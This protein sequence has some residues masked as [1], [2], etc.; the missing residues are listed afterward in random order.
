MVARP[1]Q[2]PGA[3]VTAF[4]PARDEAGVIEASVR[5]VLG[6][7]EVA[8]LVVV[9]DRSTDGTSE[10]LALLAREEPRLEVLEGRGP[11]EGECGKPAALAAAY[12]QASP[13]SEWLLFVDADVELS[14]GA[15][16]GLL[17]LAADRDLVSAIPQVEL[18]TLVEQAVMPSV[19]ALVLAA[20]GPA[21][22]NGQ[23]IL[24]RR[25]TYDAVGGHQAVIREVLE[26]VRLAQRVH[27][28]NGRLL[29][30]D[31]RKIARTRMYET[32]AELA[33]GWIKNLYP[34]LGDRR[35]AVARWVALTMVLGWIGPAVAIWAGWPY[36]VAAYGLIFLMQATLRS[37]GGA[38][39]IGAILAPAGA[40]GASYL[41]LAS[42]ARHRSGAGV[43]WKGR[44]YR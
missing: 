3:E 2:Q 25:S 35:I 44:R 18:R 42:M 11:G 14:E 6:Q 32:W 5:S 21:F 40:L 39:W 17:P 1:S 26:D 36:G 43:E 19:G 22:A 41:A 15:L 33:E 24:I 30:V 38:R 20:R 9:D 7:P 37:M 28:A 12:R 23:L 10:R 31:G 16:G 13:S 29:L 8:R 34:L 4:M 27:E